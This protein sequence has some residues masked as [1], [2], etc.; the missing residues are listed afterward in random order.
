MRALSDEQQDGEKKYE[1]EARVI[2]E[3]QKLLQR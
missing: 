2:R 3:T 1:Y